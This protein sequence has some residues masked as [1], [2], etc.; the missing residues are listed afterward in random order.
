MPIDPSGPV[1]VVDN[2]GHKTVRFIDADGNMI[3]LPPPRRGG[4]PRDK[5]KTKAARRARK[6][7]R[8]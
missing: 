4:S 8:G 5:A 6:K 3:P 1:T 7:N 2:K